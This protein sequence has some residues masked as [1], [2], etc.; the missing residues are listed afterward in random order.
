MHIEY[1]LKESMSMKITQCYISRSCLYRKLMPKLTHVPG[2]V[3]LGEPPPATQLCASLY[4][5]FVPHFLVVNTPRSVV[6][7][8]DILSRYS[9]SQWAKEQHQ[10]G[11]V[12]A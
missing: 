3:G 4:A 5:A 12:Q 1:R 7:H 11:N 9:V 2:G 10:P 8:T 6:Q